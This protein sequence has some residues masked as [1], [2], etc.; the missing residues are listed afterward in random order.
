MHKGEL[1]GGSGAEAESLRRRLRSSCLAFAA[2]LFA[3]A[4]AALIGVYG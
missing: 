4:W 2:I 1:S 3:M